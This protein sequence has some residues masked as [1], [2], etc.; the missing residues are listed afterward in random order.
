MKI[1]TGFVSNS[2]SSYFICDVCGAD[3][4][5][6]DADLYDASMVS[7]ENNHCFCEH[8]FDNLF[9]KEAVLE[10]LKKKISKERM[11]KWATEKSISRL[12]NTYKEISEIPDNEFRFSM[13]ENKYC[14]ELRDGYPA[15]YCPLC[16]FKVIKTSDALQY[17]FKRDNITLE[18]ITEEIRNKMATYNDFKKYIETTEEK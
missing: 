1:R 16:Q 4:C 10:Y 8:H 5:T 11:S 9:S 7:C 14:I 2:S 13:V 18:Q 3:Y 12:E 15:K 6:N 17:L